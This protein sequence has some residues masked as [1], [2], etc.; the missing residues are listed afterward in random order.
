[1]NRYFVCGQTDRGH[2]F[3]RQ[4][5]S[6]SGTHRDVLVVLAAAGWRFSNWLLERWYCHLLR[7]WGPVVA[8]DLRR[9]FR[10]RHLAPHP[11]DRVGEIE[12]LFPQNWILPRNK[13]QDVSRR[14]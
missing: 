12:H 4:R 1:M 6:L 13:N 9:T 3:F 11:K 14:D 5:R 8:G 7:L 10:R 2:V